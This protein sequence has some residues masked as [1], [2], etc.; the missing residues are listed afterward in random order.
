MS[1][2]DTDLKWYKAATGASAGGAKSGTLVVSTKG[3]F[4]PNISDSERA[5]GGTR[6][7]KSFLANEH[8]SDPLLLPVVWINVTPQN[9]TEEIG[10]G[11]DDTDDDANS[12]GN[13]TAW[14][15]NAVAA[16]ISDGADTRNAYIVGLDSGGNAASETVVLTGA[17]EV[18]STTVWSKV[19]A[20]NLS[21][22]SGTRTVLVKQGTGG[23][24]RGTIGPNVQTCWLW[25][26][27]TSKGAGLQL[28][29]LAAGANYGLWHRQVWAPAVGVVRPNESRI[30]VEEL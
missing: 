26:M 3:D 16:L 11:F 12:Q 4:W 1:V 5:T 13:M 24:T 7:K 20:V 23:T 14:G 6:I 15:A 19:H 25:Q 8:G 10:L 17:T 29:N 21:A 22:E 27:A 2:S 30:A 18:L 9:M 28:A